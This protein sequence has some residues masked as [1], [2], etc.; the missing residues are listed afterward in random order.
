MIILRGEDVV[1]PSREGVQASPEV[2]E[3]HAPSA[4][5]SSTSEG[6][7][8]LSATALRVRRMRPLFWSVQERPPSRLWKTPWSVPT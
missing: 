6:E 4:P 5:N 1:R 8:W 2:R 7:D 3:T